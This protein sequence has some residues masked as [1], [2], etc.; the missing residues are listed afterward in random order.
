MGID[1]TEKRQAYAAL[2]ESEVKFRTLSDFVPQMVWMCTPDGMNTYFNNRWVEYTGM[3]R[4]ESYGR[5]WNTPF[6]PDD[7][8]AAW[9]A[10]NHAVAT[11]ETYRVESRLRA[12]DGSYR[13]FLMR[14]TPLRDD[15]GEIIKWFGTC[16]DIDDMKRAEAELA[17]RAQELARSNAELQ[18]FAYVASHDLQEPLRMVASY[19]QL[20]ARRYQGRLDADA[21]EF[22][23]YAVDGARRMQQQI[24]A[25]L[26]Y[27]R[28]GQ[29]SAAFR[30][31]DARAVVDQ[32]IHDLGHTIEATDA[33]ITVEDLP[34]VMADSIQLAEVFQTLVS[35]KL[36]L[37]G[38][39]ATGWAV[40]VE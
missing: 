15:S 1:V 38:G 39:G 6:H 32:V 5:G 17:A 10:W 3:T 34:T 27:A 28:V 36:G 40:R 12:A 22:I 9:D 21:D 26:D 37:G 4:E 18:Q 20:L 16:T 29:R 14:G 23:S 19:T 25:L 8:Q 13:W 31:T 7:K 11:G 2:Q 35:G 33:R 24:Q 30:P